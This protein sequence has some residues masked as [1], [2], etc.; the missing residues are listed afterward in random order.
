[1]I[2][3][4]EGYYL[5]KYRPNAKIYIFDRYGNCER[6]LIIYLKLILHRK[7]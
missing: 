7:E 6:G 1:M 2:V 5:Y 3:K 4:H